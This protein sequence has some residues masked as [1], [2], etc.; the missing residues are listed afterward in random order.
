MGG[1]LGR[2]VGHLNFGIGVWVAIMIRAII[3][4]PLCMVGVGVPLPGFRN[5]GPEFPGV[6]GDAFMTRGRGVLVAPWPEGRG[7]SA[8]GGVRDSGHGDLRR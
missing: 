7:V 5:L 8:G 1:V 6:G 4:L 2:G 3:K